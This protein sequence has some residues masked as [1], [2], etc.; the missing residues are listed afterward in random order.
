MDLKNW[1]T[2]G[3]RSFNMDRYKD[4]I[5]YENGDVIL[6]YP[7]SVNEDGEDILRGEDARLFREWFIPRTTQLKP[8]NEA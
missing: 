7:L 5:L 3:S 4:I 1:L 2:I 8:L 6:F